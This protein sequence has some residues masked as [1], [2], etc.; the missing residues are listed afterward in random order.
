[1]KVP[2]TGVILAGG[3]NKRF[4]C[5]SKAFIRV[6]EECNL[7]HIYRVFKSLFEEIV[8]VTNDPLPYFGWDLNIVTDLFPT[9]SSLTGIHAGLF[10]ST[11]PYVFIAPCD[12]PFLK[13]ELVETIIDSV[14]EHIDVVVPETSA[15][16]EPL[17][18][19]YSKKCLKL[20]EQNIV[21]Q[22]LKIQQFYQKVSVKRLPE[23]DLR[24][25]DPDL[26]SFFNINS[27]DD[28]SR[29]EEFV[30]KPAWSSH[31]LITSY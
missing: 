7:D 3:L 4:P 12:T 18:A 26:I 24:K 6:G 17:C 22:K 2:C 31:G 14:K 1:M 23:K 25:K 19:V 11:N 21:E 13:R 30:Q 29:A 16:L 9:Q 8:L 20:I 10:F 27:P 5:A 15:G 28:L